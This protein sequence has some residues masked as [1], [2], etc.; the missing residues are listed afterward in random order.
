[1]HFGILWL[2]SPRYDVDVSENSGTPKASILIGFSIIFTIH[3][4]VFPLH[5]NVNFLIEKAAF[6]HA[7][8]FC[9]NFIV[10][11]ELGCPKVRYAPQMWRERVSQGGVTKN[12]GE[13]TPKK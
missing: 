2:P 12:G 3:F 11:E 10:G 6:F 1:M 4:G 8:F 9:L 5:R 7:P 13:R